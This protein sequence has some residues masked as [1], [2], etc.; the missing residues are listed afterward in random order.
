MTNNE[1]QRF[2]FQHFDKSRSSHWIGNATKET[3]NCD[4][5]V[6]MLING[7]PYYQLSSI[8]PLKRRIKHNCKLIPNDCPT[9]EQY[10]QQFKVLKRDIS[11][12]NDKVNKRVRDR[13]LDNSFYT[14]INNNF[15]TSRYATYFKYYTSMPMT[16]HIRSSKVYYWVYFDDKTN[17]LI[18]WDIQQAKRIYCKLYEHLVINTTIFQLIHEQYKL[19]KELKLIIKSHGALEKYTQFTNRQELMDFF[20][21]PTTDFSDCYCLAEILINFPKLENCVWNK[22]N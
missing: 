7:T 19:N 4:D 8:Y 5:L 12:K 22:S 3:F 18:K 15:I 6:V 10:Y 1:Y 14:N 2:S 9:L 13:E 21:N 17:E 11:K 20:N 16:A